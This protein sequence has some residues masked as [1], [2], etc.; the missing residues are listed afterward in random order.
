MPKEE[1]RWWLHE[2]SKEWWGDYDLRPED[3]DWIMQIENN[4]TRLL[5]WRRDPSD[6]GPQTPA[7]GGKWF[8]NDGNMM[9]LPELVWWGHKDLT[10]FELYRMWL[11]F[12]ILATKRKHSESQ[13]EAA[14]FVRNAKVLNAQETGF[15]GLHKRQREQAQRRG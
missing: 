14:Q 8:I 11:G 10:F 12:P 6:G 13:S 9:N 7:S 2:R 3:I 4:E 1:T 5:R 15:Y